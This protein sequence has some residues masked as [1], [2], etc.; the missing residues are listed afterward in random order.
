MHPF[1][2]NKAKKKKTKASYPCRALSE[3]AL[4]KAQQCLL[5]QTSEERAMETS[6]SDDLISVPKT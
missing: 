2:K 6:I 1:E 5:L 4:S 3:V